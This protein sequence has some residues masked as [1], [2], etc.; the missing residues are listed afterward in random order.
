MACRW[1]NRQRCR[2][3]RRWRSVDVAVGETVGV[4]RWRS[5]WC[6]R[7]CSHWRSRWRSRWSNRWRSRS[8]SHWRS[9]D[10][11]IGVTVGVTVGVPLPC[12]ALQSTPGHASFIF[13]I[14]RPIAVSRINSS[15][16]RKP[17]NHNWQR[18]DRQ[19]ATPSFRKTWR[20]RQP[21][22]SQK[23]IHTDRHTRLYVSTA[24]PSPT[25]PSRPTPF[26]DITMYAAK[27]RGVVRVQQRRERALPLPAPHGTP[28]TLARERKSESLIP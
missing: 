9:V 18:T 4:T 6:S 16:D 7:W 3:R 27:C 17:T 10:V 2:W 22:D 1:C 15:S 13:F 8:R 28:K 23:N 19:T 11:A 5:R 12:L 24:R 20:S 14:A 26:L 25:D 21:D